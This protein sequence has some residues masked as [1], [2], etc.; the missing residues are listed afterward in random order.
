MLL[1]KKLLQL[2]KPGFMNPCRKSLSN[3]ERRTLAFDGIVRLAEVDEE[4][5]KGVFNTIILLRNGNKVV[6]TEATGK[7]KDR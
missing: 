3:N 7:Q 1:E 6:R 5:N 4:R 2:Q